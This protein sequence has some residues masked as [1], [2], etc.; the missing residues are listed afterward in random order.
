MRLEKFFPAEELQQKE[1]QWV[2]YLGISSGTLP[3]H[4]MSLG[5]F[6]EPSTL[7]SEELFTEAA[8]AK[9]SAFQIL[10]NRQLSGKKLKARI[11]WWEI[12]EGIYL[13][14]KHITLPAHSSFVV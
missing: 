9:L 14:P 13:C 4:I 2:T 11:L 7:M 1:Q 5:L 3:F 12:R 6:I 10:V 8:I